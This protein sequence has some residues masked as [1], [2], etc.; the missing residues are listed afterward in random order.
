MQFRRNKEQQI[1]YFLRVNDVANFSKIF[2]LK[3][4]SNSRL[5][6]ATYREEL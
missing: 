6:T 4:K 5:L 2:K 1:Y 3:G